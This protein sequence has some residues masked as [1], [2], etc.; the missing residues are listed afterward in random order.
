LIPAWIM[1]G[2]VC[3]AGKTDYSLDAQGFVLG[4]NGAV[5]GF[6]PLHQGPH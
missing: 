3:P 6:K 5:P 2:P 1:N 4:D